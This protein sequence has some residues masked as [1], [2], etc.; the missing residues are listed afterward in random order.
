[1]IELDYI[2]IDGLLYPNIALDD[3]GLYSDI[4][5]Y[6]NLRLKY[7]HDTKAE[8]VSATTVFEQAGSALCQY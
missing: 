4:G 7:L 3:E 1:M 2:E 5:K 8:N 6:G